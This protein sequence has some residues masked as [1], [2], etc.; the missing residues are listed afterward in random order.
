MNLKDKSIFLF[1]IEGTTTPIAFVHKILFPYSLKNFSTFL[2]N[3]SLDQQTFSELTEEASND[4]KNGT[5]KG[6]TFQSIQDLKAIHE[7]L[8]FLVSVDRKSKALKKIQGNI[9]KQGFETG[10]LKSELFSDVLPF[11]EKIKQQQKQIAIYSSGSVSAQRL[12]FQYSQ[13]GDLSVHISNYFDT[14]V[15][16]KK[17]K[18]SY[19]N[20]VEALKATADK[21]VF[22][23]DIKEEADAASAGGIF[24]I[25]MDRPGNFPQAEH[26][27]KTLKSFQSIVL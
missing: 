25:V 17:E 23:T 9:W 13:K 10:T 5:Y 19:E 18:S 2:E 26:T 11:F 14:N 1:D 20:I 6:A 8:T 16:H 22:F 24:P 12:L 7:Y 27:Y 21:I 15:G 4:L 3:N